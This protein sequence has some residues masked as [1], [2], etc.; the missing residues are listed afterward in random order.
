MR[1]KEWRIEARAKV[2]S[3]RPRMEEGLRERGEKGEER[4]DRGEERRR[5]IEMEK[6]EERK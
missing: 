1:S 6:K 5:E 3:S 2:P 4:R